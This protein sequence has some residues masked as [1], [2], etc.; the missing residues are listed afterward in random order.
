MPKSSSQARPEPAQPYQASP[1]EKSRLAGEQFPKELIDEHTAV[2][3]ILSGSPNDLG[4]QYAA[5]AEKASRSERLHK[6]YEYIAQFQRE[7]ALIEEE[8]FRCKRRFKQ[9]HDEYNFLGSRLDAIADQVAPV[10]AW[11]TR[12][13]HSHEVEQVVRRRDKLRD[14]LA[15]TS[16]QIA[17]IMDKYRRH[18]AQ[19]AYYHSRKVREYRDPS[20]V[21]IPSSTLRRMIVCPFDELGAGPILRD[22]HLRLMRDWNGYC[23]QFAINK[24]EMLDQHKQDE[25]RDHYLRTTFNPRYES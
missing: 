21:F 6:Y 20:L 5:I 25:Q 17:T 24:R 7:H 15:A 18:Q 23:E 10:T 2:R 3:Q 1:R 12:R 16:R 11:Y 19:R 14:L 22:T 13:K 4:T 9:L 8:F